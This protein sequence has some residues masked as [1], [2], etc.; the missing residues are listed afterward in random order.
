LGLQSLLMLTTPPRRLARQLGL[1][2]GEAVLNALARQI[3][4][5]QS[6]RSRR[7]R[8]RR[9]AGCRAR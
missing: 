5:G 1:H 8:G 6:S 7:R 2:P 4:G 9:W 3:L